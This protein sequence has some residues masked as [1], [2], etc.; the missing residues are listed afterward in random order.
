MKELGHLK[1]VHFF[2]SATFGAII[3]YL[4]VLFICN[5]V[6]Y[7][8]SGILLSLPP[9]IG[10]FS[11]P[12][13][14]SFIE[15]FAFFKPSLVIGIALNAFVLLLLQTVHTD[16]NCKHSGSV[17]VERVKLSKDYCYLETTE[18]NLSCNYD[19]IA[20]S[21]RGR[22]VHYEGQSVSLNCCFY[23]KKSVQFG[24]MTNPDLHDQ[25]FGPEAGANGSRSQFLPIPD[26]NI[27]TCR[28]CSDVLSNLQFSDFQ[29]KSCD[30][31]NEILPNNSRS[32]PF[33][34]YA[35]VM[36]AYS[37]YSCVILPV[38]DT[39]S[40]QY[41]RNLPD[42]DFNMQKLWATAGYGSAALLSSIL[43]SFSEYF[44]TISLFHGFA[45]FIPFT[46]F[47]IICLI[48]TSYFKFPQPTP[49]AQ[50]NFG[51]SSLIQTSESLV[52]VLVMTVLGCLSGIHSV[53]FVLY[54]LHS[55]AYFIC[56]GIAFSMYSLLDLL[57]YF[58]R[59][60]V[61]FM[62]G[63][64]AVIYFALT[65]YFVR[66]YIYSWTESVLFI[67]PVELLHAVC[68][69]TMWYASVDLASQIAPM[70]LSAAFQS[71]VSNAYWHIGVGL[72]AVIGGA[73]YEQF[74]Y[75]VLWR[76]SAFVALGTGMLYVIFT[77]IIHPFLSGRGCIPTTV[78]ADTQ[79]FFED[80]LD[81]L[82]DDNLAPFQNFTS[83]EE[84]LIL[85]APGDYS[86]VNSKGEW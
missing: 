47:S 48:L 42:S 21:L 60:K 63:P 30:Q 20:K 67:L 9:F 86:I 16:L 18:E 41:C 35:V 68:F 75:V 38:L 26:G 32:D 77:H 54:L 4:P 1:L 36:T 39:L 31:T 56:I 46:L 66:F 85:D 25:C 62:L 55:G 14:L 58:S 79:D 29:N 11:R 40:V 81:D 57:L 45:P 78:A 33:A 6:D 7:F 10:L 69:S 34:Q 76:L 17:Q 70:G 64:R 15:K 53:F 73:V 19:T 44:R 72:G 61:V 82:L 74:D 3:P 43:L 52:F 50:L 37:F 13:L 24:S 49:S 23:S 22:T 59:R 71:L 5:G 51:I 12:L 80:D 28:Q 65:T 27:N 2:V 8:K 83:D 84:Y